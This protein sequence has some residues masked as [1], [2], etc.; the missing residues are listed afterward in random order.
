[1]KIGIAKETTPFEK[2][3]SA[4][5]E[6]VQKL[7]QMGCQVFVETDAGKESHFS[8]ESFKKAGASILKT[9]KALYEKADVIFKV[10]KPHTA[11][12]K[13]IPTGKTIIALYNILADKS[14]LHAAAQHKATACALELV[15][16]ITRAQSMD[17]LSSQSNLAGYKAV[18]EATHV[19]KR[20][21]PL[22]MTAAGTVKPAKV[23]IIGA[24]VAGLQAIATAKR[25]GAVVSA[26]DVRPV[27]KEQVESLGAKFVEV[28]QKADAETAGGYAKEMD[29]EYKKKQA[30]LMHETLKETDIVVTT[31]LIPGKPAPR[32]ITKAM[33]QDMKTGSV[34]VDL[35]AEMGGNCELTEPGKVLTKEGVTIIGH[36]NMASLLSGNAS[37]LF[38]RN[39]L[40]YFML[41]YDKEKKSLHFNFDDDIITAT[42]ITHAGV[43]KRTDL[44]EK[45]VAVTTKAVKKPAATKQK[46]PAKKTSAAKKPGT[47][48]KAAS[49][50]TEK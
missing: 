10:Q 42:V 34:I 37:E 31:A 20:A 9:A 41:L 14:A 45:K 7:I 29:A 1:M 38:A 16:R 39:L 8:D 33:V 47:V 40:N 30:A 18:L 15:P 22:M 23:L 5:P 4:T 25:L 11:E 6:T 28:E 46:A 19:F 24:G 12:W 50:K 27:A 49:K 32:L 26:F 17:V 44:T 36:T 3:V 48:K 35:A 2:R 21:L 43:L 13:I